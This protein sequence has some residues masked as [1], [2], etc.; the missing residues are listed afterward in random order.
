VRGRLILC[1]AVVA[2]A[3][4]LPGVADAEA[5]ARGG[6]SCAIVGSEP[7]PPYY[8]IELVPT[9]RVPGTRSARGTVAVR[10]AGS[11]F[12]IGV[13]PDG[14]Y[15]NRLV[16]RYEGLRRGRGDYVVW[17]ARADL[18]EAQALGVLGASGPVEGTVAWNKFIVVVSLEPAGAEPGASW[19]GP[20]VARG[21]SRSGMMHTMAGHGPFQGEPCGKYGY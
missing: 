18:S 6:G 13:T 5:L 4:C 14:R 20:I 10:H 1:G 3:L 15:A 17:V 9:G 21:M 8:A 12:L 19:S 16:V 11:P 2:A 7:G